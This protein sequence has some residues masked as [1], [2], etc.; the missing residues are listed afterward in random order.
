MDTPQETSIGSLLNVL[1]PGA[2]LDDLTLWPPDVFAVTAFLL[3]KSGGYIKAVS[4][5]APDPDIKVPKGTAEYA[6]WCVQAKKL[7]KQWLV[8][9]KRQQR[10]AKIEQWWTIVIG[11]SDCPVDS[12]RSNDRLCDALI[13]L[14]AVAD[15]ACSGVGVPDPQSRLT[16]EEREYSTYLCSH[17]TLCRRISKSLLRVL[18]KMHTPQSGITIRSLSHHLALCPAGEVHPH[19]VYM[20]APKGDE[21]SHRLNLLLVPWP[22]E[23]PSLCFQP[24]GNRN[25]DLPNMPRGF[26]FFSFTPPETEELGIE[27]QRLVNS[28]RKIVGE[29]DGVVFPELALSSAKEYETLLPKLEDLLASA[30]IVAGVG[31]RCD[32]SQ[33]ERN[34]I[35]YRAPWS[36]KSIRTEAE[37]H[38]HHRWKLD[39]QQVRQY[40]LTHQ[41][42][43]Y[44]SWWENTELKDRNIYFFAA[45]PWLAYSFLICEDLAR[46]DPVAD[47]L[48]AVGPNLIIALLMD[49]PQLLGR[50]AS[51]YATVFA[52]DPGSSVLCLTSLGMSTRS[53]PNEN[54]ASNRSRVIGLWKDAIKGVHELELPQDADALVL[55]VNRHFR[56]EWTAD[57]RSDKGATAYLTFGG[58]WP[59]KIES[60]KPA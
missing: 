56:E 36:G 45:H 50:W 3:Q 4:N 33:Y 49:G 48:R 22:K 30:F 60:G 24:T 18:P 59:V 47:I 20:P 1:T 13:R 29:I 12:I 44:T 42:D 26:S 46:Q 54:G 55:S 43:P 2:S 57:G 39:E 27:L 51:R 38:K 34:C 40:G 19:W 17:G 25:H 14:M 58:T 35:K 10:I 15:E 5:W 11:C 53:T 52:D 21:Y 9:A 16:S 23:I 6:K 41:L 37:Q 31:G 7:G 32:G 28:A 8:K